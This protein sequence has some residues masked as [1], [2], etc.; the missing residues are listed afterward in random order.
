MNRDEPAAAG[1]LTQWLERA[2][3]GDPR[4]IAEVFPLVYDELRRVAGRQIDRE[5]GPRTIGATALV[6]EAFIKLL[7]A[8][9]VP[10][11]DR[12]HFVALAARAMRQILIDRARQRLAGKRG[13]EAVRVTM[14][15]QVL[16]GLERAGDG[17]NVDVIAVDEALTRL[18]EVDPDAANVVELRF[19]G[20]MTIEEV[21]RVQGISPATVK[22]HWAFAQ[23]WLR[24][25][26][27]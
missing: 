24:R 19:F 23:T 7:P 17:K 22:R 25:E 27:E 6:H 16:D 8:G 1:H 9:D 3:G 2:R 21:A 20:G 12:D 4:A 11:R 26:L 14:T 13:G 18:G 5:Y 15:D 10:A